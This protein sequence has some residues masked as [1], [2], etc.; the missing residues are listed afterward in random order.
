METANPLTA[1][2]LLQRTRIVLGEKDVPYTL[3]EVALKDPNTGQ[4]R[5]YHEKPEWFKHCNPLG[6]S[7]LT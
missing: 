3:H 2:A 1:L 5:Q 4:W 6:A 7:R